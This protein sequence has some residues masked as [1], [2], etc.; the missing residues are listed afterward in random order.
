MSGTPRWSKMFA[1]NKQIPNSFSTVVSA[2]NSPF[3]DPQTQK[4]PIYRIGSI[5]QSESKTETNSPK[6]PLIEDKKDAS[7]TANIRK[8]LVVNS[9]ANDEGSKASITNLDSNGHSIQLEPSRKKPS[10]PSRNNMSALLNQ[11]RRRSRNVS[12]I[13]D[14]SAY[15][16][17]E[18]SEMLSSSNKSYSALCK[19]TKETSDNLQSIFSFPSSQDQLSVGKTTTE[20]FAFD[21]QVIEKFTINPLSRGRLQPINI[22]KPQLSRDVQEAVTKL[23]D[24]QELK[25]DAIF[26]PRPQEQKAQLLGRRISTNFMSNFFDANDSNKEDSSP[27]TP[28]TPITEVKITLKWE[29]LEQSIQAP[30]LGHGTTALS[31]ENSVFVFG[32]DNPA[33][34]PGLMVYKPLKNK[35]KIPE[36]IGDVPKVHRVGH[37]G[38]AFR[39]LLVYFGGDLLSNFEST[40]TNEVLIYYANKKF[41]RRL[42]GTSSS[43]K[44]KSVITPRKYHTAC[45]YEHLMVVYGGIDDEK[46]YCNDFWV[47][48]TSSFH[49]LFSWSYLNPNRYPHLE[50]DSN[51]RKNLPRAWHRGTCNVQR[52]PR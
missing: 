23:T 39:N 18:A 25:K 14:L 17:L 48:D 46:N 24:S 19:S 28:V 36:C 2:E 33:G 10:L 8:L 13:E 38:V 29:Q 40:T 30:N 50:K 43:N 9:K 42:A 27:S 32:G 52:F 5:L 7:R 26:I 49:S 16:T 3:S 20:K 6:L 35:W 37:T 51:P 21:K 47:F 41:W 4:R 34:K 44:G 22:P 31:I 12:S 11:K 15:G 1:A 45:K